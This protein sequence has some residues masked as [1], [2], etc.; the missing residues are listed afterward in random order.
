MKGQ[1]FNVKNTVMDNFIEHSKHFPCASH[2]HM[3]YCMLSFK[4]YV[5]WLNF[6]FFCQMNLFN[7]SI[8][9]TIYL[10][11][12]SYIGREIYLKV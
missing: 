4:S 11:L 2:F 1:E 7:F 9:L 6:L 8:S 10:S 3:V 5:I 12:C